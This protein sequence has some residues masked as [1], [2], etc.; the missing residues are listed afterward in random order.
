[1]MFSPPIDPAALKPEH[2]SWWDDLQR[3]RDQEWGYVH[4]QRTKPQTPAFGLNDSPAGLAAWILEKWWR[5]SDCADDS[6]ERDPLNVYTRDELL[7]TVSLY[8]FT[9]SIGPSMRL[10]YE[11]FAPGSTYRIPDRIEVPTGVSAFRD[12]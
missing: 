8:W 12:P 7:T 10:Y 1:T 5:W 6:G 2:R 9:E 4:M 11:T 3:Y